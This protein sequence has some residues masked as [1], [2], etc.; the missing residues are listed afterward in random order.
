[1]LELLNMTIE[2]SNLKRI[3]INEPLYV[4]KELSNVILKLH[5]MIMELS[6][7]KKKR[8]LPNVRK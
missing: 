2:P 4:T 5:N 8:K 3:K 1:M 6:N 7:V